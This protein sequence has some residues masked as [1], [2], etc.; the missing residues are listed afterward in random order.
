MWHFRCK[1]TSS[2]RIRQHCD[3]SFSQP[4]TTTMADFL[5]RESEILGGEF[6]AAPT[7]DS[8]ATAS[9]DIDFDAAASAFPEISLDGSTDITF[10]TSHTATAPT[11]SGFSFDD[12]DSPP[13]PAKEIAVTGNDEIDKF[14]SDFPELDI[15]AVSLSVFKPLPTLKWRVMWFFGLFLI[16][17]TACFHSYATY[18]RYSTSLCPASAALGVHVHSYFDPIHRGRGAASYQVGSFTEFAGSMS[19]R[20][21]QC[22]E[23][24]EKQEADIKARDE[25][26]KAKREEVISKAEHAIDQFYEE[27]ASKKERN[28]R[29]N[30]YVT[31]SS[32]SLCTLTCT[33]KPTQGT[34]RRVPRHPVGFIVEWYNLAADLR[35]HRITKLPEQNYRKNRCWHY[36]SHEVQGG[37]VEVEEG[38][39]LCPWCSWLLDAFRIFR[40]VAYYF[41]L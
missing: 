2:A 7:G 35:S 20:V 24:R 6:S 27:Y 28:I 16:V 19:S 39:R 36:G 34:R 13:R 33:L 41:C 32:R 38:R 3:K 22:R 25:A 17:V 5:A 29:E 11:N 1:S 18:V 30:K 4:V 12:F 9:G 23:W 31:S 21:T 8:F 10:P 40:I 14:E 37:S 15:P 26:S